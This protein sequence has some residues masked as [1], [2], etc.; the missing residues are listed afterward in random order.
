[1]SVWLLYVGMTER[2]LG[3]RLLTEHLSGEGHSTFFRSIGAILDF[4]PLPGSLANKANQ[5][6]YTFGAYDKNE[7]VEWIE[8][9]LV[10]NVYFAEDLDAKSLI[11]DLIRDCTPLLNIKYGRSPVLPELKKLRKKCKDIARS[12]TS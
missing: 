11:P 6:N 2:T 4:T 9:N 10:A 5:D 12:S 1:M 7:I 8:E 3:E